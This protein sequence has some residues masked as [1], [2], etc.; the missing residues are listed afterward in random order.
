MTSITMRC[1]DVPF[2]D[3]PII[4]PDLP[5]GVCDDCHQVI[6]VPAQATP[7]IKAALLDANTV[8]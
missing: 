2:E 8:S 7:Q 4:V 1:R 3:K 5:V 6:S